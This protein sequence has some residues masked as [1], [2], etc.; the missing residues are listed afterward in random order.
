M[1][2]GGQK[3]I[4]IEIAVYG[5]GV[6]TALSTHPE[7]GEFGI[8]GLGNAEVYLQVYNPPRD[9]GMRPFRK[10]PFQHVGIGC[11]GLVSVQVRATN[12]VGNSWLVHFGQV[13]HFFFGLEAQPPMQ[14]A[15]GSK[16]HNT[17]TILRFITQNY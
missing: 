6:G 14:T 10:I 13:S 1:Y 2:G 3:G 17:R 16:Q 9:G 4:G 12:S 8:P 5:N 7:I 11:Y 15:S